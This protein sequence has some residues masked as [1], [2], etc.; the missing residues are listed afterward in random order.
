MTTLVEVKT[1][2]LVGPALDWA[3]AEGLG[4]E[5]GQL[6]RKNRTLGCR[7]SNGVVCVIG[8]LQG[9]SMVEELKARFF[10]P[11]TDWSQGG[12]LI[13]KHKI[14]VSGPINARTDWSAAV[15][16]GF[17]ESRGGTALIALCR[18]FVAVKLGEVVN[19]PAEL[20]A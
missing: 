16:T 11:S 20:V 14:W 3:V 7:T 9:A 18:A 19:V 2:E 10:R 6:S 1:A 13:D 5:C 17:D 8:S 12:P 4:Y 15:D